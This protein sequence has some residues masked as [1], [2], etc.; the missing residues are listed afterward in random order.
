MTFIL[1]RDDTGRRLVALLAERAREGLKVRL[2][3]DAVGCLFSSHGFTQPLRAAGGEV[4]RFMPV[5]LFTSRGSA[6]L[7]LH[8]KIAV[9]DHRTAIIGGHN[10]AGEY[11]GPQPWQKRFRD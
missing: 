7:R 1:W 3:L 6:N 5:L 10:L 9:F 2:L 8:R 11:M 4:G